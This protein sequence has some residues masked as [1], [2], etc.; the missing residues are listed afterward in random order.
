GLGCRRVRDVVINYGT[1]AFVLE[2]AG[3]SRRDAPGL[4]RTLLA[5]WPGAQT[6]PARSQ[7]SLP[8]AIF[9]VEGTVNDAATAIEWAQR[10]LGARREGGAAGPGRGRPHALPHAPPG[11]GGSVAVPAPAS[12]LPGRQRPWRGAPGARGA[13]GTDS[14][15]GGGRRP[16]HPAA[17]LAR[18][19]G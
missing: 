12:R 13:G 6:R 10:R 3:T 1:G 2:Y 14:A 7:A 5:S 11:A 8:Q 16:S 4:L 19:G 18:R 15:W 9:A 17:H